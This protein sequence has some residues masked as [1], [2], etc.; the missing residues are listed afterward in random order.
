M[1]EIIALAAQWDET[2]P[3]QM[4][5]DLETTG[6][7]PRTN[8]VITLALGTPG[9]VIIID[10]RGYYSAIPALQQEWRDAL[11][12]LLHREDTLWIGHNIKF[13]W[14]FLAQQFEVTLKHLYDTMLVEKLLHA[15]HHVSAS[16][17][18][19][20]PDQQ[21]GAVTN[22][23]Y[24]YL[25]WRIWNPMQPRLLWVMLNPSTADET[26]NDPTLRRILGFSR[27]A[28]FGGLEVVNLY[29]LRSPSPKALLLAP[30]AIGPE[31]DLHIQEAAVRAG[32]IVAGWGNE[33]A[34]NGRD[35]ALLALV[36]HPVFCLGTTR[37][38]HPR[39]PL[40]VKAQTKLCP[41]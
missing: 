25:L 1:Q 14:S 30:D 19:S 11:Q 16:L 24:R 3:T 2:P 15:G 36:S 22:G 23:P 33:G 9:K 6:L 10:L 32:R 29:A 18:L 5:L 37:Q 26:T 27:A 7:N 8:K 35:R 39:H 17:C 12:Q 41:F 38:G 31:N 40:Y 34:R 21:Q 4:V 20:F 13:D 28:G